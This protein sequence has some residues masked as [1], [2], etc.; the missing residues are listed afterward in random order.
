M[1]AAFEMILGFRGLGFGVLGFKVLG[2]GHGR[3]CSLVW[4][5]TQAARTGA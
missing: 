4:G 2:C 3:E 1:W 5:H